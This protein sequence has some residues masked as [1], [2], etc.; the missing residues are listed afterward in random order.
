MRVESYGS[1]SRLIGWDRRIDRRAKSIGRQVCSAA[2]A[3]M[4]SLDSRPPV[5]SLT[6]SMATLVLAYCRL[7]QKSANQL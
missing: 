7:A 4:F 3:S 2:A 1:P 5:P 6:G